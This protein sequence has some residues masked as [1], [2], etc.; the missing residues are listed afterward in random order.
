MF[1]G[2]I[3]RLKLRRIA[4]KLQK[5]KD[6]KMKDLESENQSEHGPAA[7]SEHNVQYYTYLYG[8]GVEDGEWITKWEMRP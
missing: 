2:Y 7:N 5:Q 6:L 3:T 8:C 4:R 1:A